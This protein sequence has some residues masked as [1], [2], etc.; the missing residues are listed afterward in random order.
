[1]YSVAYSDDNLTVTNTFVPPA[2]VVVYPPVRKEVKGDTKTKDK[3]T[4]MLKSV[5]NT[6][7][8]TFW[9]ELFA[10]PSEQ[11][12]DSYNRKK[13][14]SYISKR[15]KNHNAKRTLHDHDSIK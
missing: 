8:T 4:F 14:L 12:S 7:G 1:M 9:F 5:S 13:M 11:T 10:A 3:V 6:A 2:P 15:H